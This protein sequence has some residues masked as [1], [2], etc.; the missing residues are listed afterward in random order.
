MSGR[1]KTKQINLSTLQHFT[2]HTDAS[3]VGCSLTCHWGLSKKPP[4]PSGSSHFHLADIHFKQAACFISEP[5]RVEL[6]IR[7]ATLQEILLAGDEG[8][9]FSPQL[10]FPNISPGN[11]KP[12]TA[13]TFSFLS[14]LPLSLLL[15]ISLSLSFC[16]CCCCNYN[17]KR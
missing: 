2:D 12:Q 9:F 13:N 14:V 5:K 8:D 1:V 10:T 15:G 11:M 16:C 6:L 17:I 7:A 4:L 3:T